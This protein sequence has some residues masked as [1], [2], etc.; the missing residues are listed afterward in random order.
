MNC[1][2]GL[3]EFDGICIYGCNNLRYGVG[4]MV[5]C[6]ENCV[7]CFIG[8][9]CIKCLLGYWGKYCIGICYKNCLNCMFMFECE[10]CKFGFYG[11]W[12]NDDCFL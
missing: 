11:S 2:D 9:D 5:N 1:V 8:N 12:C 3:C 4:C 7:Y 6:R 10:I